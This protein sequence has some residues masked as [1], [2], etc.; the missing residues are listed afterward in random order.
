[1]PGRAD[2]ALDVRFEAATQGVL[3]TGTADRAA[4]RRVRALPGPSDLHRDRK[5]RELYL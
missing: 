5:L 2:V 3:A 1:M 4:D